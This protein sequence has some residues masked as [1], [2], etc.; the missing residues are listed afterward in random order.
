MESA[1]YATEFSTVMQKCI[2]NKMSKHNLDQLNMYIITHQ[3]H[4]KMGEVFLSCCQPLCAHIIICVCVYVC[5]QI[6]LVCIWAWVA[7][8]LMMST[9]GEELRERW[10][11]K[12]EAQSI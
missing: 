9:E 7:R 8:S 12:P 6:P 3:S 2:N 5:K 1:F 4:N 11:Q 10:R